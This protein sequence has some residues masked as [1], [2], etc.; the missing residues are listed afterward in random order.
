MFTLNRGHLREQARALGMCTR[1]IVRPARLGKAYCQ[2]CTEY[3]K[4]HAKARNQDKSLDSTSRLDSYRDKVMRLADYGKAGD[5]SERER[6]ARDNHRPV[7][8]PEPDRQV[9]VGERPFL[10]NPRNERY[11][12]LGRDGP[13][14]G[15][16]VLRSPIPIPVG[17]NPYYDDVE[18]D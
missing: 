13:M 17:L 12:E 8:S 14:G 7:A 1:C 4:R 6:P 15:A 9:P 10:P 3:A 16:V 18:S 11:T 5:H 2:R